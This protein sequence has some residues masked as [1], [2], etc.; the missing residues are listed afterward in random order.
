MS[1]R[2]TYHLFVFSLLDITMCLKYQFF[3]PFLD[4]RFTNFFVKHL[5]FS[6]GRKWKSAVAKRASGRSE[7]F[8]SGKVY[9]LNLVKG[10]VIDLYWS[11]HMYG[12][13]NIRVR[14]RFFDQVGHETMYASSGNEHFSLNLSLSDL[15][16]LWTEVTKIGHIFS[17]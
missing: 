4:L 3:F 13:F 9:L 2:K 10:F 5:T 7:M 6:F 12:A 1:S 17:K 11:I 14:S 8:W 16:K 15:P